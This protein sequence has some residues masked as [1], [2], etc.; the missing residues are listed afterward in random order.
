[1][2]KKPRRIYILCP[3]RKATPEEKEYLDEYVKKLES[4]PDLE[5]KV[6]YPPRDV[7]QDPS[8]SNLEII[9]KHQQFMETCDEVHAYWNGTSEGGYFDLG[10]AF[11]AKCPIRLINFDKLKKTPERSFL[12]SLIE[13]HEKYKD[14][15]IDVNL[16]QFKRPIH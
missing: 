11:M 16:Y 9:S 5:C 2:Q 12:N 7:E 10:M 13:L 8:I 1:M 15:T 6:H 3:V 4:N 14:K